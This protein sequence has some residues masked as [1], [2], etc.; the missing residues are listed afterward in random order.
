MWRVLR[1]AHRHRQSGKAL[2]TAT[3]P[4]AEPAQAEGGVARPG[5]QVCHHLALWLGARGS[6]G[7]WADGDHSQKAT[8]CSSLNIEPLLAMAQV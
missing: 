6:H 1:G 8:M 3:R 2:G 7:P 4:A 5:G